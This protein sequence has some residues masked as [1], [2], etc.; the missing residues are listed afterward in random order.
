MTKFLERQ[1]DCLRRALASFGACTFARPEKTLM[2]GEREPHAHLTSVFS[3]LLPVF[4]TCT[5]LRL[6]YGHLKRGEGK[7]RRLMNQE[8]SMKHVDL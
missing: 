8:S 1:E 7:A 3:K 4:G 2:F 6:K 5:H